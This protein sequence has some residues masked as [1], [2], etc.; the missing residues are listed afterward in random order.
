MTV[1]LTLAKHV[2]FHRGSTVMVEI[3]DLSEEIGG[4]GADEE[5]DGDPWESVNGTELINN[6]RLDIGYDCVVEAEEECGRQD[7]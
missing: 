2:R 7:G 4:S 3:R 1:H 5:G 6:N